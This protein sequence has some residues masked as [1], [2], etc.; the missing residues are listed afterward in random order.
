MKKLLNTLFVTQDG[1]YLHK[2]RETVSV[3]QGNTKLLQV[4]VLALSNI[5]CFGRVNM[6]QQLMHHC[7]ENSIG[8]AYF[9][10]YGRFQARV[11]GRKN[12]NVLL[13][14]EQYR[15][16]DDEK[17]CVEIAKNM[18]GAKVANSRSVIAKSIRNRPDAEGNEKLRSACDNMKETLLRL[19][20]VQNLD[21][22][23]GREGEAA[24]TYFDVF[25]HLI[26]QQ[27]Q[28]FDFMCRNRRPPKDPVNALLS[29]VYAVLLQ[30]CA[31]ALEAVGLDSY[32]GFL[33]R[34]KPGR[35]SLALDLMEEF[36]AFVGD[37][38]C[39]SLINLRQ[40]QSTNF[41]YKENGAV[42][43]ADTARKTVLTEYQKRKQENIFHPAIKENVKIGLLFHTQ[44]LLLARHIRGDIDY[45]PAFLW[46]S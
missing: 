8:V 20:R 40:I 1:A 36:R 30:D 21:E 46:R 5:F 17:R 18:I 4:P 24:N 12:G 31:S 28:D 16:A 45:Y 33:H 42:F 22:L 35:Q 39:L 38:L 9:S 6:S 41:S 15:I 29:F 3:E 13:R 14:R 43:I 23:R 11:V 10:E 19:E 27:K 25:E 26:S 32:V 34:D 2:I 37:R 44:A 7:M